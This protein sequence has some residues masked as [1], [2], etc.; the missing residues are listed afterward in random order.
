M[1][2]IHIRDG[3]SRPVCRIDGCRDVTGFITREQE[4]DL[5]LLEWL[6]LRVHLTGCRACSDYRR[7]L[8]LTVETLAKLPIPDLSPAT[9]RFLLQQF[10]DR[11]TG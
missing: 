3:L 10:R 6:R 2:L 1:D 5:T 7:Q 4:G 9:R 8:H 11:R